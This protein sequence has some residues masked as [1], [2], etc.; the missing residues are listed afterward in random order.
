MRLRSGERG[1]RDRDERE[2]DRDAEDQEAWE[3]IGPVGA[4]DGHLREVQEAER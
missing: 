1:D 4:V 2:R 3:E